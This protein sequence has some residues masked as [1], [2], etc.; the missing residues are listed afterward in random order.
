MNSKSL[1][2]NI[3]NRWQNYCAAIQY[4]ICVVN[5]HCFIEF[6]ALKRQKQNRK[7]KKKQDTDDKQRE[8]RINRTMTNKIWNRKNWVDSRAAGR[9]HAEI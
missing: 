2:Q 1:Q 6:I 4:G 3:A 7:P 5:L 9:K 8:T